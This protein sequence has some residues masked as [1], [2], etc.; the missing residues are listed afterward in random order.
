MKLVLLVTGGRGGSDFFQGH[1]D[2]HE[3]ILQ[4]PGILRCEED[5]ENLLNKNIESV[6]KNFIKF[7]P[8]FFDSR[9]NKLERHD[10]LGRNRNEFYKVNK[11]IFIKNFNK[12]VKEKKRYS[13]FELIKKLHI[14]YY[15]S[16]GINI[17]KA[18]IL[19]IHTHTIALTKKFLKL[20]KVKNFSIIYT[21]RHP[22]NALA[23]PIKNWLNFNNGNSFF[24]KDLYFQLDLALNGLSDLV[25]INRNI[26]VV[27]LEKLIS[28]KRIVMEDFCKVF[29]ISFKKSLLQ[30]T[31]F[32]KQWWGDQISNRWLGK[33]INKSNKKI[34]YRNYFFQRDLDFFNTI[35]KDIKIK[36]FPNENFIQNEK[37]YDFILFPLKSELLV[38]SNTFKHLRFKHLLSIPYFF[39]KRILLI[40]NYF[41]K[42]VVYPYSLGSATKSTK[43]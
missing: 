1:L 21:M 38:W 18:K 13:N 11:K 7:A 8:I 15:L 9:L 33:K 3:Q 6:A 20:T 42:N 17:K 23:S 25:K 10:K 31:Y 32:G 19:F 43:K 12:I 30:C 37:K 36:Y 34:N 40:N 41:I 22:I 35:L 39:I 5:F 27:L 26:K 14:A 29:K 4:F 2:N 28:D 24:P 16:R